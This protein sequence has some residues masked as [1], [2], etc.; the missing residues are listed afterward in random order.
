MA[1]GA[2][3]FSTSGTSGNFLTL[4]PIDNI[5][6]GTNTNGTGYNLYQADF[7]FASID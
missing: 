2:S 5:L 3:A 4:T 7:T 1:I 6:L